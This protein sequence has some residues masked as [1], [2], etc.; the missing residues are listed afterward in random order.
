MILNMNQLR[1]FYMAANLR[2]VSGAAKALMVTPPAITLQ[3]KQLEET[4]GI[5]LL[6]RD[7]NSIRLTDAG[8]S[9]FNRAEKIFQ[10]I[11]EM[12]GFLEDMSTGKSGELRIGCPEIPLKRL[13]PM[14]E[15]FRK[16]YP[17][18][19]II[20]D[21]GSNADMVKSIGDHRNELAVIRYRPSNSRLK[22]KVIWKDEVVLIASPK[23]VHLSAAE[24]S[25]TQLSGI[26]L[27]LRREGSA[28]REVVLEYLR[29]FKITP[30]IAMESA[31]VAL[32]KEF[33]RQDNGIGFV[34]R[35]A[36]DEELKNETLQTVRILEG[37]P[38][39]EF[40]IG[41]RDRRDLSPPAWAF[42]RLL[43]KSADLLSVLK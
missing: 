35:D 16:T 31:S 12:E 6:V 23:S 29:K 25:V 33:V 19:R 5:R 13:M 30:L 32:L 11:H 15:T 18:I 37:S 22:I 34:E 8:A 1:S 2:S 24:I 42:L 26:P 21:Q 20:I 41:Y 36:V 4:I 7:G 9:V 38:A 40:G 17:G 27:I 39:I 28:V 14:I 10:E 3:V 43:D